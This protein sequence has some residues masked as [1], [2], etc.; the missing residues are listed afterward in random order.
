MKKSEKDTRERRAKEEINQCVC[1]YKFAYCLYCKNHSQDKSD[2]D[3]EYFD[4]PD[5]TKEQVE[6]FE[7]ESFENWI[8][9]RKLE[10]RNK[11]I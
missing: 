9:A 7:R 3:K 4:I 6:E 5:L 2:S 1:S 11:C 8:D 10:R